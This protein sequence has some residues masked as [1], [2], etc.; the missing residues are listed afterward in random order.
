MKRSL[1]FSNIGSANDENIRVFF[2]LFCEV[3]PFHYQQPTLQF[4][5]KFLRCG[6]IVRDKICCL[7][8]DEGDRKHRC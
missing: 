6:N 2:R 3:G 5:S 4:V 7:L 1:L 8:L